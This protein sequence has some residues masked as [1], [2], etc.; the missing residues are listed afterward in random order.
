MA[1]NGQ[2]GEYLIAKRS[3]SA[4]GCEPAGL[5]QSCSSLYSEQVTGLDLSPGTSTAISINVIV[6]GRAWGWKICTTV[7]CDSVVPWGGSLEKA[8]ICSAVS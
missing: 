1:R 4:V 5:H 8:G 7:K 3:I 2:K 6:Q